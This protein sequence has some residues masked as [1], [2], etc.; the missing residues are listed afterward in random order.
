MCGLRV[1]SKVTNGLPARIVHENNQTI[2]SVMDD[3]CATLQKNKVVVSTCNATKYPGQQTWKFITIPPPPPA[4]RR[5]S[6]Q[7]NCGAELSPP[8]LTLIQSTQ[9]GETLCVDNS[10]GEPVVVPAQCALFAPLGKDAVVAADGSN[11][12]VGGVYPHATP[13]AGVTVGAVAHV[14]VLGPD[15]TVLWE[16]RSVG[17]T[18][19][20]LRAPPPILVQDDSAYAVKDAPRIVPP[21]GGAIPPQTSRAT[22]H[23][24]AQTS[25][26]DFSNPADDVY[27]FLFTTGYKAM[28]REFLQLTGEIPVLP[29]WAFGLWFCWYHPY[30]QAE[31]MH[32]IQR[33]LDDRLG[34]SVASLD[35]DWRN[36]GLPAE[37]Q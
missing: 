20:N 3:K 2:M 24:Y 9:Q 23:G 18:P 19:S 30:T 29:H 34:L 1:I 4:R 33:F 12:V 15:G 28:R 26:Y 8:Q 27:I 25:G 35:R 11:T 31:K 5:C 13:R 22:L 37:G 32:E 6:T 17:A 10:V 7:D 14:R 21:P 16:S 36:L